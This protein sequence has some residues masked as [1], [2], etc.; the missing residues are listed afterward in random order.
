[1]SSTKNYFKIALDVMGGDFAPENEILGG[2]E[3]SRYKNGDRKI[4]IVFLGDE[5]LIRKTLDKHKIDP[6][7]F[8]IVHAAD[9]FSMTDSSTAGI[10]RKKNTSMYKGMELIA[11]KKADAFV[12]SG[13]TGAML[14][15][16]TI[17]LGRIPGVSRP[18][19]GSFFPSES[20]VPSF[21]LDVGANLSCK[22][23]FLYEFAVMGSVFVEATA[24]VKSPTVALLNIGEESAKGT[25]VSQQAYEMMNSASKL[26]FIGNVE[27]RD[28]LTG[29][30]N[31]VV[32]DG[33]SGNIVLKFAESVRGFLK[34]KIRNFGRKNVFNTSMLGII[35][36]ILKKLFDEF[37]YQEYGGVPILGVNGTVIVG[38]GKS[39]PKAVR[40][41]IL[42]AADM[43]QMNVNGIIAQ[44]LSSKKD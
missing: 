19:I 42:K 14:A 41:M 40:N 10:R 39:S 20:V 44:R 32:C 35:K 11:G 8:E 9:V 30:A 33:F 18:A 21:V 23:S 12:S 29:K 17:L 25:E 27:G 5:N 22:A 31:V 15:L 16:A 7:G 24:G 37:D 36:P 13:N 28:I 34:V 26:N 4:D 3:A 43:E 38:H 1:M 2:V 6:K